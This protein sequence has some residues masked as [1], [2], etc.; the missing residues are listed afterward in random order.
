MKIL[1]WLAWFLL[2]FLLGAGTVWWLFPKLGLPLLGVSSVQRPIHAVVAHPLFEK[3]FVCSE[4]PAGQ[5]PLLGDDLGQD[6]LV[7]DFVTRGDRTWLASYRTDGVRNEDWFGWNADV[8]SPCD[9]KV[10][11]LHRNATTNEPGRPGQSRAASIT[12]QAEDGTYFTLA[13]LG[14]FVVSAGQQVAYGQKIG[15]VGNNGF[16]RAPHIHIGAWRG[17]E[18]LQIRWDQQFLV[19]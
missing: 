2:A 3:T 15:T 13:H 10:I 5:L 4:H 1:K 18:G 7:M 19:R 17:R 11:H 12:L 14:T 8:L 16:S 9:C 6:C